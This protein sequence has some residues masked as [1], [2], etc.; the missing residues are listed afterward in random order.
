MKV[1]YEHLNFPTQHQQ[2]MRG[3][4]IAE[5]LGSRYKC[6]FDLDASYA[7]QTS[8]KTYVFGKDAGWHIVLNQPG[9]E[10]TLVNLFHSSPPA[11]QGEMHRTGKL[12]SDVAAEMRKLIKLAAEINQ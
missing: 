3:Q 2:N 12:R 8:V 7:G 9:T 4:L 11:K 10:N 1:I 6:A 5:H